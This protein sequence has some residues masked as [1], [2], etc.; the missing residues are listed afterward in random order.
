MPTPFA[1]E[2]KPDLSYIEAAAKAIAPVLER[3]NLVILES[4]VP[5]G[6]T[7]KLA[8]WLYEARPD[9]DVSNRQPGELGLDIAHC[10]ERV[11]PGS[12]SVSYTHLTL[13]TICSV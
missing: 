1:G 9:L 13:P 10:P 6:T 12:V 5:V 4:T 2:H 7:E 11:L 8:A 3:G